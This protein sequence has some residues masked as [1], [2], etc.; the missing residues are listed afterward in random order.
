[1]PILIYNKKVE[2]NQKQ[3]KSNLNVL[4]RGNKKNKTKG[5]LNTIKYI[6]DLY[7]SRKK[8]TELHNDYAK[9]MSEAK[10]KKNVWRRN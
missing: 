8:V 7:E 5:Q 10:Y 4:T 1:M 3:F 6:K 9:I 2:E